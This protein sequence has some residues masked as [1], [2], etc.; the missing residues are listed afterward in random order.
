MTILV[1]EREVKP[2]VVVRVTQRENNHDYQVS[3]NRLEIA[4]FCNAFSRDDAIK[5]CH[6]FLEEANKNEQA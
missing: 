3:I 6:K 5:L 4:K 1:F 2:N